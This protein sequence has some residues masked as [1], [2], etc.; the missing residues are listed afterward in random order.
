MR[1]FR[2]RESELEDFAEAIRPELRGLGSP[3]PRGEVLERIL[4]SRAQGARVILPLDDTQ[5]A[6]SRLRFLIPAAI[7]AVLLTL[8]VPLR[9]PAPPASADLAGSSSMGRVASDWLPV[10]IALAQSNTNGPRPKPIAF[11]QVEKLRPVALEYVRNWRDAS[12]RDLGRINASVTVEST[13]DEGIPTW[14]IVT[15]N[16]GAR[17]GRNVLGIDSLVV[18]RS[19]L[20]P[21][22]RAMFESPYSRYDTIRLRQSFL[23]DSVLASM[24]AVGARMPT[25]SRN[26]ARRLPA[27]AGPYIVD[28]LPPILL[29][30]VALSPGWSG[31]AS[32]LG[33]TI[34]DDDV[35]AAMQLRVEREEVVAVP[36]GRFDCW[37]MS[38]SLSGH[39]LAFWVR[40]AD[41]IAVRSLERDATGATQDIVLTRESAR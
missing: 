20:R 41:G 4:S 5:A 27:G 36:A 23:G 22:S 14:L 33:W 39:A 34:R 17:R 8:L 16:G 31:S 32:M 2:R 40:K 12:G 38:V 19:D 15:R 9:K 28:G 18:A 13:V 7:A 11:V 29:G 10:A 37:R 30:A 24:R 21:M 6:R 3:V 25:A 1:W 26:A 35:S